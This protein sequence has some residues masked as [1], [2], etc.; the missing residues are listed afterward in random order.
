MTYNSLSQDTE[1]KLINRLCPYL[2]NRSFIDIGAEKGVFALTLLEQGLSGVLFEPMPRHFP[3]LKELVAKHA[4]AKLCTCAITN[5]DTRQQFNVATNTN[6]EEL[7]FYHSLQK[8]DAPEIFTHSKSFEVECRSLQ[9]LAERGEI[10][11]ELGILKTDTEGNDLNVLRGL[12]S[13]YP[14][15][16]ICEYFSQGLYNGWSEGGPEIIIEYMRGLGYVTYLATKRI[17]SLEFIGVNTALFQDK[18]W[19]N[20]FFF[21]EDFYMKTKSVIDECVMLNEEDLSGKFN[22]INAEL[23][24]KETVIQQLISEKHSKVS[25]IGSVKSHLKSF[26]GLNRKN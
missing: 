24:D 15:L 22:K 6:G 4:D 9:S 10:P 8:A 19:G 13:L 3:I 12:G 5:I 17:G 16:V 26:F 23:E 11:F 25:V 7:D 18:Q 21:R 1:I 14:E 20:L 2:A